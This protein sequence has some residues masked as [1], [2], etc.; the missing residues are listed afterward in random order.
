MHRIQLD[1]R[2][3]FYQFYQKLLLS[4]L[5][6]EAIKQDPSMINSR[7][8][9]EGSDCFPNAE[10]SGFGIFL[11]MSAE[12]EGPRSEHFIPIPAP[13]D[14]VSGPVELGV[15]LA[16]VADEFIAPIGGQ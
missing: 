1:T 11:D 9:F 12:G 7:N 16:Q 6:A 4:V 8:A 10:S 3:E 13:G 5:S 14:S 2:T 15:L